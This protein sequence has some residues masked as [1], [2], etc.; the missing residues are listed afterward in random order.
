MNRRLIRPSLSEVKGKGPGDR[1]GKRK[2]APPEVT[3]AE[4]YYFVKQMQA[5]T[6]MVIALQ[7]GETLRGWIEWYDR[8]C[9]KLHRSS[10]PNLLVYKSAVKYMYKDEDADAEGPTEEMEVTHARGRA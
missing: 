9:V 2:Q 10:G 3:S 6:P 8:D 5:Q 7:D 1:S 4:A